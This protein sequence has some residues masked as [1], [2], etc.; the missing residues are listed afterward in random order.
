[1][2]PMLEEI[3]NKNSDWIR[4]ILP[5]QWPRLKDGPMTAVPW[6]AALL[7]LPKNG[8]ALEA[9]A[10]ARDLKRAIERGAKFWNQWEILWTAEQ[11]ASVR[12]R[13]PVDVS[14]DFG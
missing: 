12:K 10:N 1:M 7:D 8:D 14:Q 6:V 2:M 4:E 13:N 9:G 3:E 11:L 5:D